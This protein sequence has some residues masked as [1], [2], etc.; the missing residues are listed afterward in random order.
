MNRRH[1]VLVFV[2]VL[3][4]LTAPAVAQSP[5]EGAL[6]IAEVQPDAGAPPALGEGPLF[7][8]A[9]EQTAPQCHFCGGPFT[10]PVHWGHGSD[11]ASAQADVRA[12]LLDFVNADCQE[13]GTAGRCGFQVVYTNACWYSGGGQY[14]SDA[15]ASYKCWVFYC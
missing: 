3:L 14:T 12:Q 1:L 11:C 10:S 2:A 8:P 6:P 15:Y 7:T 9:P 13:W 4:A 5:E